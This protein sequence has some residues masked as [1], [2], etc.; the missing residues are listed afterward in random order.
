MLSCQFDFGVISVTAQ[1]HKQN[2][3][4]TKLSTKLMG[5]ESM[6]GLLGHETTTQKEMVFNHIFIFF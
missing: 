1:T 4:V 3:V 6:S 2:D 5:L